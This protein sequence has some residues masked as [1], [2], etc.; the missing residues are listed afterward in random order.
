MTVR[1]IHITY[2]KLRV[3]SF[4]YMVNHCI[5]DVLGNIWL[6]LLLFSKCFTGFTNRSV[7][8]SACC[9]VLS[10]RGQCADS[11]EDDADESSETE[12]YIIQ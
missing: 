8:A 1:K 5:L 2:V 12:P 6:L 3:Y 7:A 4:G 9:S 10:G 11:D